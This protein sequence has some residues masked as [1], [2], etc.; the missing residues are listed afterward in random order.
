[1]KMENAGFMMNHYSSVSVLPSIRL[2]N[3]KFA[4]GSRAGCIIK[5]QSSF[6]RTYSLPSYCSG[7]YLR[8]TGL[9]DADEQLKRAKLPIFLSVAVTT[10]ILVLRKT[11]G[12]ENKM[13]APFPNPTV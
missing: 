9:S 7:S 4:P 8:D 6:G 3:T 10:L 13:S 5:Q 11:S 2:G 12:F 1:M